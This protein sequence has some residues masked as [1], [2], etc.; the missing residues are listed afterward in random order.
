MSIAEKEHSKY[1]NLWL[2][3]PDYR[4]KSP[5]ER[6]YLGIFENVFKDKSKKIVDFG[7]GCGRGA[8][9]LARLGFTVLMIDITE[10][11]LDPEVR[12]ACDSMPNL[13]FLELNLIHAPFNM[14][15]LGDYFICA[16]VIEHLPEPVIDKVVRYIYAS[17]SSSGLMSVA[18]FPDK[19]FGANLHLTVK[20][21]GYWQRYFSNIWD[22]ERT[23]EFNSRKYTGVLIK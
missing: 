15:K 5:F 1:R 12:M 22:A 10:H 11:A 3:N 17:T 6:D 2:K 9:H 8:L 19:T 14:R 4:E 20:P 21:A 7:C 16:D 13:T 23:V 18:C